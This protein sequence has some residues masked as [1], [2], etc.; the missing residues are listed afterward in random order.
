MG[1]HGRRSGRG[2][3]GIQGR[4]PGVS[5][6][7]L[8]GVTNEVILPSE[9]LLTKGTREVTDSGMNHHVSLD[10]LPSE[11]HPVTS[12][13]ITF[14]PSLGRRS[15]GVSAPVPSSYIL[16]RSRSTSDC[17]GHSDSVIGVESTSD[18]RVSGRGASSTS[19]ATERSMS[20][21]VSRS[22]P[23]GG[24]HHGLSGHQLVVKVSLT[25]PS[26][27]IF[28][29][30]FYP[31]HPQHLFGPTPALTLLPASL[32]PFSSSK[33]LPPLPEEHFS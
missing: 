7:T 4:S 25:H 2:S 13:L 8:L 19:I 32:E 26:K 5:I 23:H 17:R 22:A 1:I 20:Q 21:K 29:H 24:M 14:E 18:T 10:I 12:G 28:H 30:V 9:P 33:F 15:L 31:L 11:E 3:V 16:R 27:A 6:V